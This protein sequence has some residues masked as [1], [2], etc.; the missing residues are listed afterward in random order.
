MHACWVPPFD[1]L[2]FLWVAVSY[3]SLLDSAA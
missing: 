3:T 2:Y 1:S